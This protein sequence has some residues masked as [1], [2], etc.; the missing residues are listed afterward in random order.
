MELISKVI[1]NSAMQV[2]HN[3]YIKNSLIL[4]TVKVEKGGLKVFGDR[5]SV[6]NMAANNSVQ[7]TT[8]WNYHP[9]YIEIPSTI[10]YK[11]ENKCGKHGV[12]VMNAIYN[13]YGRMGPL[14]R[15]PQ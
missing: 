2:N 4:F 7:N 14:R 13:G 3:I 9:E 8:D 15:N 6:A 1:G 5:I 11:D 12:T 10:I